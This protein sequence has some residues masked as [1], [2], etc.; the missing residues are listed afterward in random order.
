MLFLYADFLDLKNIIKDKSQIGVQLRQ[1]AYSIE[2]QWTISLEE[3][4][5]WGEN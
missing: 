1:D 3:Y 4:F 2:N 5:F